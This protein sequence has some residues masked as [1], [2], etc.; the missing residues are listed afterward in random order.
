MKV[1]D[2][3]EQITLKNIPKRIKYNDYEWEYDGENYKIQAS[4]GTYMNWDYIIFNCLNDEVEIIEEKEMCH[5]CHKYPA[6]YNQT[7][8]E[9]CLGISKLE[10]HKIP[11]KFEIYDN[12]IEWCC[13]GR[14]ITDNEKDIALAIACA[15]IKKYRGL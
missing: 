11:E 9:F 15:Y 8:C 2:L 14:S 13:N 7:Y 1:I 12:S 4:S 6:E 10:E 5:K 3:V